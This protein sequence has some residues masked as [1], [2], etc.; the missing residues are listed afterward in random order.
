[1]KNGNGKT[2]SIFGKRNFQSNKMRCVSSVK[3]GD[4]CTRH[5]EGKRCWQHEKLYL[6][7]RDK[8]SGK[9]RENMKEFK[10]GRLSSQK[11]AIAI[12]FSQVR[13]SDPK[14]TK[15]FNRNKNGSPVDIRSKRSS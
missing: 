1:M 14:C 7:C 6:E 4:R 2:S 9:I 13:K 5:Q 8:L 15:A 10:E 12:S 11:Q 3:N